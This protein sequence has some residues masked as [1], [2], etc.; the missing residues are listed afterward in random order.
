[1]IRKNLIIVHRSHAGQDFKEIGEKIRRLD[2]SIA[3]FGVPGNLATRLPDSEWRYR[4]LTV[5]MG[6]KFKLPVK[7]GPVLENHEIPKLAQQDILGAHGIPTPPA[8]PFRFA[9]DLDRN[10]FGELVVVKPM[11]LRLTSHGNFVYLFRRARLCE[12]TPEDLPLDHPVRNNPH[13]FLVQK[14]IHT[15][16]RPRCIRVGTFFEK[17]IF[18]YAIEPKQELPDL[19]APDD[20]LERASVASNAGERSRQL[21]VED[22]AIELAIRVHKAF[23]SLPLLGMDIVRDHFTGKLYVLETNAGGNTWTFSSSIGEGTRISI[24]AL[25]HAGGDADARGRLALIKQFGAFD[26]VA[27]ALVAKT[28]ELAA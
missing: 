9:M 14:Y 11:D 21:I 6:A 20:L 12:L 4:T 25:T 3:V 1:M 17:V 23:G 7:R 10:L 28:R 13:S 26:V 2:A 27:R 18:S 5:A 24:G 16:P 15:G 8:L 19:D 22:D